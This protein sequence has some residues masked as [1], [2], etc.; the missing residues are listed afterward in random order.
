MSAKR[1][2]LASL[3]IPVAAESL[4][5]ERSD[6][7]NTKYNNSFHLKWHYIVLLYI[8]IY[9]IV[10]TKMSYRCIITK[11][12]SDSINITFERIVLFAAHS[13]TPFFYDIL[14]SSIRSSLHGSYEGRYPR[15]SKLKYPYAG[16]SQLHQK[17]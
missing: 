1:G 11:M 9:K 17:W 5:L 7:L 3:S 2:F 16:D 10:H 12:L 13:T 6:A 15:S 8:I 14:F 4:N